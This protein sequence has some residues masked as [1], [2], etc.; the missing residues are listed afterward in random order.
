MAASKNAQEP[1]ADVL[2][3]LR[4]AHAVLIRF[5]PEHVVQLTAGVALV[6]FLLVS[7]RIL[8]KTGYHGSLGILMLVPGANVALLM[9]LAFTRWPI[10]RELKARRKGRL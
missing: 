8:S 2:Q 3:G 1:A 6:T 7:W 4:E 5:V 10:E 9:V